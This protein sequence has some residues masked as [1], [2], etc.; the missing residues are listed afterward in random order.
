MESNDCRVWNVN[1]TSYFNLG[2]LVNPC[3]AETWIFRESNA[4]SIVTDSPTPCVTRPPAIMILNMQCKR[5]LCLP[6]ARISTTCAISLRKCWQCRHLLHFLSYIY[7]AWMSNYRWTW[8]HFLIYVRFLADQ[9]HFPVISINNLPFKQSMVMI[10][11]MRT[12][13]TGTKLCI[14]QR[15]FCEIL[16]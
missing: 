10:L 11:M 5:E 2:V 1:C 13:I 8:T 3:G 14:R 16:G 12:K 6:L 9:G 15:H 7:K 4:I